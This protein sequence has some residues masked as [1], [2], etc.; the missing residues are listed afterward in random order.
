VLTITPVTV[1]AVSKPS[2]PQFSI[3]LIDNSYD[4]PASTT[5]TIDPYTGKESTTTTP[6]RRVDNWSIEVTIKNQPFKPYTT[7]YDEY[8]QVVHNLYYAVHFKGHFGDEWEVF[9]QNIVQSD[10]S[11]TIITGTRSANNYAAGTQL[12]FRVEAI[13]GYMYDMAAERRSWAAF[14]IPPNYTFNPEESS[15]WSRIQTITV[16]YETLLPSFSQTATL[17]PPAAIFEDSQPQMQDQPQTLDVI[18]NQPFFLLVVGFLFVGIVVALVLVFLRRH[19]KT[20]EFSND[21][22]QS[23]IYLG[24]HIL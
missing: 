13:V 15:G 3:K 2:V 19:L 17:P 23:N 4:I 16:N 12:D 11:Y 22:P 5:T 9:C 18:F 8:Q 21:F 20:F 14:Y 7:Q 10:S 6:G 24:H 1:Q